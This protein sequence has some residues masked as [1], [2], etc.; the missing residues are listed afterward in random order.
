MSRNGKKQPVFRMSEAQE[1]QIS[2]AL[3]QV[4]RHYNEGAGPMHKDQ[5]TRNFVFHMMDWHQ[6][7]LR[8][9]ALYAEPASHNQDQWN[10]VV[11]SFLIHAVGH[12]VAAA[13]LNSSFCDPF[14]AAAIKRKPKSRRKLQRVR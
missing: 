13:K 5:R 14:D 7:L 8:L 6:D 2:L 12:A 10:D 11:F 9:A 1:Q 3:E 4:F